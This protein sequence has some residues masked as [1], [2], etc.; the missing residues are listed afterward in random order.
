MMKPDFKDAKALQAQSPDAV[1][2][3]KISRMVRDFPGDF[4]D[5]RPEELTPVDFELVRQYNAGYSGEEFLTEL[6]VS[7]SDFS[8][9][10]NQIILRK[11]LLNGLKRN[12]DRR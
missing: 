6:K 9:T 4:T 3:G 1:S 10:P 12:F 8:L 5:F 7:V 11:A 2:R